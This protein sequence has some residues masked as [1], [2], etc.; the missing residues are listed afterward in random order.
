MKR[1]AVVFVLSMLVSLVSWGILSKTYA[2]RSFASKEAQETLVV[3]EALSAELQASRLKSDLI[4]YGL[5]AGLLGCLCGMACVPRAEPSKRL[6]GGLIG[7]SLGVAGGA[8]GAWLGHVHDEKM[9]FGGEAMTYWFVRWML[10]LLPIGGASAL[11]AQWNSKS[12]FVDA[13]VAGLVGTSIAAVLL[14]LTTGS[15]TP[16]ELH[17]EIFPAHSSNR[18]LVLSLAAVCIS[19]M[20]TLQL[21]RQRPVFDA[22]YS[23]NTPVE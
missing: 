11:A 13:V 6:I 15:L 12:K 16:M 9:A 22:A 4:A 14:C 5:F 17:T 20:V 18:L 8:A 2:N 21:N 1:L 7:L 3:S 19:G 10:I 23:T